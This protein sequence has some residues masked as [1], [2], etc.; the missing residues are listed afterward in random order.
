MPP[1]DEEPIQL[2]GEVHTPDDDELLST[3]IPIDQVQDEPPPP[4]PADPLAAIDLA[5]QDIAAQ[6][7]PKAIRAFETKK[8]LDEVW[9]RQP[10]VNGTG[11]C[12]VRTFIAKLRLDAVEHLDQQVNEW[13]DAHPEY[14]VKFVSTSI[15]TLFA[16]TPEPALFMNVWV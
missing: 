10:V 6:Q 15:G 11:A 2:D 16:K 14:E 4:P 12:H 5:K 1:K 7:K 8:A 3:A 9:K 13:L